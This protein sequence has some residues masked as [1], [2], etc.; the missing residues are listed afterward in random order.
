MILFALGFY[1]AFQNPSTNDPL[2]LLA[3]GVT[4]DKGT[5][6]TKMLFLDTAVL[7]DRDALTSVQDFRFLS[8]GDE[9]YL[10]IA[11]DSD[12]ASPNSMVF[13]IL[14]DEDDIAETAFQLDLTL[15]PARKVEAFSNVFG[16]YLFFVD[17][18]SKTSVYFLLPGETFV[19]LKV[20]DDN[21]GPSDKTW[22]TATL[23]YSPPPSSSLYQDQDLVL[24]PHPTNGRMFH[25]I[26][27]N[28]RGQV[29]KSEDFRLPL[30]EGKSQRVVELFSSKAFPAQKFYVGVLASDLS[31]DPVTKDYIVYGLSLNGLGIFDVEFLMS[32]IFEDTRDAVKSVSI[33]RS[34][35]VDMKSTLDGSHGFIAL[36][37]ALDATAKT[38][39]I[40]TSEVTGSFSSLSSLVIDIDHTATTANFEKIDYNNDASQLSTL[41]TQTTTDVENGNYVYSNFMLLD[42]G[43]KVITVPEGVTLTIPDIEAHDVDIGTLEISSIKDITNGV[44]VTS[45]ELD[46]FLTSALRLDGGTTNLQ[47]IAGNLG[48]EGDVTAASVAFTSSATPE[49]AVGKVSPKDMISLNEANTVAVK[50]KFTNIHLKAE[51]NFAGGINSIDLEDI[52]FD[53]EGT[54]TVSGL[55]TFS[56]GLTLSA[57]SG[58]KIT[59]TLIN[60]KTASALTEFR[61]VYKHN[62]ADADDEDYIQNIQV[63]TI[64]FNSI[65]VKKELKVTSMGSETLFDVSSATLGDIVTTNTDGQEITAI[66]TFQEDVNIR[67]LDTNA[68]GSTLADAINPAQVLI[69][70]LD[71]TFSENLEFEDNLWVTGNVE[72]GSIN[73]LDLDSDVARTDEDNV[74]L[75][76][77]TFKV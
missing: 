45:A 58:D 57:D 35:V 38:F 34:S 14:P 55:K 37:D 36:G 30:L 51:A 9:S 40:G 70:N 15:S 26:Y 53:T 2:T 73:G 46:S 23:K 29:I 69:N 21:F 27:F 54:L 4:L 6:E 76:P 62:P 32:D 74:F 59:L 5:L 60:G 77:V 13:R 71:Q 68:L 33:S 43:D 31:A 63:D 17:K 61:A 16:H 66:T 3:Y 25:F 48:L 56:N 44:T 50:A 41:V 18:D 64:K 11:R 52:V 7:D 12:D 47:E 10:A 22:F 49:N 67:N 42:S 20:D 1:I 28:S 39:K 24:V 19:P 8:A 75:T 65:K 72:V